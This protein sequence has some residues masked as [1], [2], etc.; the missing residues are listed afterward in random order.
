MSRLKFSLLL[1]LLVSTVACSQIEPFEDRRREPGT[2]Y[3]YAGESKK[4][5]P[6]ICYNPLFT[7]MEELQKQADELC[8]AERPDT[9]AVLQNKEYFSCRLFV[10]SK[11]YFSC[12]SDRED[13]KK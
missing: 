3:V 2:D 13:S 10:P 5:S 4:D 8:Q 7:D 12:R 9:Y 1:S 6:V 11:A